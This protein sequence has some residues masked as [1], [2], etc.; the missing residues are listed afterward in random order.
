MGFEDV[1]GIPPDR[2]FL[3]SIANNDF[4]E[5][6][7]NPEELE[8]LVGTTYAKLVVPGLS[9]SVKQF[10]NTD[11]YQANFTL[12]FASTSVEDHERNLVARRLLMAWCY[13]RADQNALGRAGPPRVLFVWPTL[14]SLTC[15]ITKV[16]FKHTRFNLSMTPTLMEVAVQLEEIRD[17][18]L[19]SDAV[20]DKGTERGT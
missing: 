5:A 6:Q 16:R 9:H 4:I 17:T 20:A 11:D 2:V 14:V 8:E 13:P 12:R 10:V 15:V 1:I 3:S 7:Y 19:L 18:L